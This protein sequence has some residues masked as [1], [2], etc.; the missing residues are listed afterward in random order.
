MTIILTVVLSIALVVHMLLMSISLWRVW[1]G[2]NIIDRLVS[3]DMLAT[4]TLAV[5][6]IVALIT[7]NSMYIDV[8]LGLAV[9]GFVSTIAFAKYFADEQ[10]F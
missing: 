7:R 1:R 10:V 3:A 8:A 2:E 9:L 4:I 6:V 5:I